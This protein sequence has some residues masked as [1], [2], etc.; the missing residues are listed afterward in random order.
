MDINDLKKLANEISASDAAETLSGRL[1]LHEKIDH[2]TAQQEFMVQV[3]A[4]MAE[5]IN[6]LSQEIRRINGEIRSTHD[7]QN[8]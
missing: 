5:T 4:N 7:K 6:E 8:N 1:S 3:I 2:L